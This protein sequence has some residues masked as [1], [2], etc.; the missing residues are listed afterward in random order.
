MKTAFLV[1]V[2]T[3]FVA[4][5]RSGESSRPAARP[6]AP[7]VA[8]LRLSQ[9]PA[10]ALG[11]K[12][13]K[14]AGPTANVAVTGRLYDVTTGYAVMKLM[15]LAIPY[16]GETD[17]ADE[18][19]TPWDYCCESKDT[20]ATNSLLVEARGADGQPLAT[21]GL[22]DLELLDQVTVTGALEKDAHGNLVLLAKGWYRA[23]RP[24][25]PDYVKWP[26]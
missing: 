10:N 19:R 12:A 5:D 2:L 25:V 26:R 4:C 20:Q 22:G 24:T 23:S 9:A 13:A 17:K 8:A 14:D 11:V 16:C 15:D 7:A 3:T 6:A 18:C 1:V 21:P